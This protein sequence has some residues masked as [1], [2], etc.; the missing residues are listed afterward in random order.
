[1]LNIDGSR[2][3]QDVPMGK[4]SSRV[5]CLNG[6]EQKIVKVSQHL[7]CITIQGF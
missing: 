3:D 4:F 7:G 2:I 1:M 5:E 6:I